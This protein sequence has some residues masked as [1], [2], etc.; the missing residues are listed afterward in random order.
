MAESA[1]DSGSALGGLGIAIVSVP[2]FER[3]LERFGGRLL[4]RVFTP[5]EQAYARR[6]RRA[7]ESLAARFAAKI[8]GRSLLRA[9]NVSGLRLL[10][11]EVGRL[12]SG[13]PTLRVRSSAAGPDTRA[14]GFRLS[15][16]HDAQLALASL[17]AEE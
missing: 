10:D 6:K 16:T 15:L 17:W 5:G 11:L 9:R 1:P 8:A 7:A 13:E 4:E 3:A 14:L 12:P 2:R